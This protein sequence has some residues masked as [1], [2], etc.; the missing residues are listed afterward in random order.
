MR[1]ILANV[2]HIALSPQTL[3]MSDLAVPMRTLSFLLVWDSLVARA[4]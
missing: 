3:S 1:D 2:S 4:Q